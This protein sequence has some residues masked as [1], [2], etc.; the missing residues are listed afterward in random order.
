MKS[1]SNAHQE[2]RLPA[3]TTLFKSSN[4]SINKGKLRIGLERDLELNLLNEDTCL[5]LYKFNH[6]KNPTNI[7]GQDLGKC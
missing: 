5:S 3:E 1:A 4:M 2:E 6:G 7:P